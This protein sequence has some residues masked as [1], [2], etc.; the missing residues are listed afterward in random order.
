MTTSIQLPVPREAVRVT[1]YSP[2]ASGGRGCTR[3]CLPALAARAVLA[4]APRLPAYGLGS[5]S[6]ALWQ[7]PAEREFRAQLRASQRRT[8]VCRADAAATWR[9]PDTGAPGECEYQ[10]EAF[11]AQ[12]RVGR[13]TEYLVKWSGYELGYTLV[14]ST[15]SP[16]AGN[17]RGRGGVAIYISTDLTP[18]GAGALKFSRVSKFADEPR[19]PCFTRA[20]LPPEQQT[21]M[22]PEP[23]EAG[24]KCYEGYLPDA[25]EMPCAAALGHRK[26]MTVPLS[27]CKDRCNMRGHCMKVKDEDRPAYCWC[28]RSFAGETCETEVN[29]CYKGCSGRGK[30]RDGFCHCE[31]P[32]F[33][34]ELNT[35]VA[36]EKAR[37]PGGGTYDPHYL[38]Y[39][40]FLDQ[41]LESPVRTENPNEAQM[42]FLPVFNMAYSDTTLGGWDNTWALF[43]LDQDAA[44][45]VQDFE[46]VPTAGVGC[47]VG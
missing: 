41:V 35:Q 1:G 30:C 31:P 23:D 16:P 9:R 22:A 18:D 5:I 11:V 40:H 39:A 8:P 13:F 47:H 33:R 25:K 15:P 38:A 29:T 17:G 46:A 44:E 14:V 37:Q 36:F 2:H 32:Y 21:S 26:E 12:R 42:F 28:D 34:Y 6:I 24:V 43:G 10:V 27:Q 7:C 20:A 3:V 45:E 19:G 4:A